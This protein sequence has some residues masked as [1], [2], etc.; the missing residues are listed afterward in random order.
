MVDMLADDGS[1]RE[2]ELVFFIKYI[3]GKR[4]VEILTIFLER[5][6]LPGR[7]SED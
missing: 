3:V 4:R 2:W 5:D 1:I 6:Y 7:K